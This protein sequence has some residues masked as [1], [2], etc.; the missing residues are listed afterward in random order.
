[1][2][3]DF[4]PVES[5]HQE[6]RDRA[7]LRALLPYLWEYRGRVWLAIGCLALAKIANVSAPLALKQIVDSLDARLAT[8]VLPTTLLLAYGAL[9]LGNALFSELRDVVFARVRYRAMRRL[10]VR[11]L[12]HLHEL[13]LRFHLEQIG[14]AHV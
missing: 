10:T 6:R 11:T 3:P 8:I 1:M 13:S 14:R 2:R 12:A 4:R 5:P 7:N 9:K